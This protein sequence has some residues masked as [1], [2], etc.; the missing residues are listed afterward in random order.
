MRHLV[1]DPA[2]D[3][4]RIHAFSSGVEVQ[5]QSMPH[6]RQLMLQELARPTE[7]TG[8]L[9]RECIESEFR[10]LFE[11]V[12]ELV[13]A[14]EERRQMVCFSVVGQCLYYKL[15]MPVVEQLVEDTAGYTIDRLATHI[16]ELTLAALGRRPTLASQGEAACRK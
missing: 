3:F 14:P 5:H 1:K 10:I 11:I 16:A 8:E 2:H 7:A 4:V 6:H 12:S 13:D 9:V 15:A